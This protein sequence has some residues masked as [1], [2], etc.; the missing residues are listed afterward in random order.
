MSS[1]IEPGIDHIV[2]QL[3]LC[4]ICPYYSFLFLQETQDEV[5]TS[6]ASEDEVDELYNFTGA[7]VVLIT[8]VLYLLFL[9]FALQ[10]DEASVEENMKAHPLEKLQGKLELYLME[11]P[12]LGFN[13]GKYDINTAKNPFFAH[14]VR[15]NCNQLSKNCCATLE[16][17]S[18]LPAKQIHESPN[19]YRLVCK[20]KANVLYR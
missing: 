5:E 15:A 2:G 9:L 4:S 16:Q 20:C 8:P 7:Q 14:L 11:L 10:V 19:K 6:Q 1:H 12:V 13:S 3:D 17:Q 18:S